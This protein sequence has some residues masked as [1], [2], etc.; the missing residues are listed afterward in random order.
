MYAI[1][2]PL[3]METINKKCL[4]CFQRDK[5][6]NG[7]QRWKGWKMEQSSVK[8]KNRVFKKKFVVVKWWSKQKAVVNGRSELQTG[9]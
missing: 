5:W 1:T 7:D 9:K 4:K 2:V 3:I 6:L 8:Q